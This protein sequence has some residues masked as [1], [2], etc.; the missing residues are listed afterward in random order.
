[1]VRFAL[2]YIFF[3]QRFKYFLTNK[4]INTRCVLLHKFPAISYIIFLKKLTHQKFLYFFKVFCLI[5]AC[6]TYKKKYK[7]FKKF[8]YLN[9]HSTLAKPHEEV[10]LFSVF[11]KLYRSKSKPPFGP[12][13][14]IFSAS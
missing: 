3:S 12:I 13:S 1:M 10:F 4:C 7:S 11:T 14:P 6:R 2:V 5:R 9:V 8:P